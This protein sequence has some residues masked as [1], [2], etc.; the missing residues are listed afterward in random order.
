MR[1]MGAPSARSI[2][3]RRYR[4]EHSIGSGSYG[5][6]YAA[7]DTERGTEVALKQLHRVDAR[8]LYRFKRE[9]R[10]LARL[11][12]PNLV[13]LYE[14]F[15]EDDGWYLAMELVDG[16]PITEH[17][18]PKG[19]LPP[20]SPG[21]SLMQT[22]MVD[23]LSFSASGESDSDATRFDPRPTPLE[24][25]DEDEA[26]AH[27][28]G[29][30]EV[31][32]P[33]E[34]NPVELDWNRIAQVFG[35]V[36]DALATL[37]NAGMLHRDLKPHNVLVTQAGR[38]VVLDFG[39]VTELDTRG[40]GER[41]GMVIGTPNYMAPEQAS[42]RDV[43]PASDLYA[44]GVILYEVLTGRLPYEHPNLMTLLWRKVRGGAPK[45]TDI[46]PRVPPRLAELCDALLAVTPQS[47]PDAA[48]V[49]R[50][51]GGRAPRMKT[52]KNQA[53]AVVGRESELHQLHGAFDETV[54]K[55]EPRL[56]LLE[57]E[58]GMGKSA[59]VESFLDIVGQERH[60]MIL[61]GCCYEQDFVPYKAMDGLVDELSGYLARMAAPQLRA[62]LPPHAGELARLF[63]VFASVLQSARF[64]GGELLGDPIAARR[65][66]FRALRELLFRL[67]RDRPIV[68]FIDD[69]QW[70]DPQSAEILVDQLRPPAAPP[71]LWVLALRSDERS[72]PFAKALRERLEHEHE[73]AVTRIDLAPLP[74]EASAD[75]A[76]RILATSNP[77]IARR[78]AKEAGGHP[79]FVAEL[80]R[81]AR[82]SGSWEL[83]G[84]HSAETPDSDDRRLLLS[85]VLTDRLRKLPA[86]SQRLLETVAVAGF[87]ISAAA[88]HR[89]AGLERPERTTVHRLV[90]ARLLRTQQTGDIE[91]IAPYHS[92]IRSTV[93]DQLSPSRRRE[94][95]RSVGHALA[96]EGAPARSLLPHFAEA[97]EAELA[98][99]YAERAGDDAAGALAFTEAVGL[100][101]QALE[102]LDR[103]DAPASPNDRRELRHKLAEALVRAGRCREGARLHEAIARELADP[104]ERSKLELSAAQAY[105]TSGAVRQGDA[106]LEPL[107]RRLGLPPASSRVRMNLQTA[108][109]LTRLVLG[110]QRIADTGPI[111]KTEA[112]RIRACFTLA[113]SL[114]LSD[115][116]RALHYYIQGYELALRAGDAHS[117]AVGTAVLGSFFANLGWKRAE[118]LLARATELAQQV[119]TPEAL[120]TA[121]YARGLRAFMEDDWHTALEELESAHRQ[122]VRVRDS[123]GVRHAALMQIP[124]QLRYLDRFQELADRTERII[125]DARE[126][127]NPYTEAAAMVDRAHALLALGRA[128][129]TRHTTASAQR[130]A[131]GVAMYVR[132]AS[133]T[134]DTQTEL[135]LGRPERALERIE[136]AWSG[137]RKDGLLLIRAGHE[138]YGALRAGALLAVSE[139]VPGLRGRR[140]RARAKR[141]VQRWLGKAQT[142]FGLGRRATLEAALAHQA[143]D[144]EGAIDLL[145]LSSRH[146]ERASLP[147]RAATSR[148]RAAELMEDRTQ[149]REIDE[150][151]QALDVADPAR[152]T[153]AMAPGLSL[154]NVQSLD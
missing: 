35:D 101:E 63:P 28:L 145:A 41:T 20:L 38:P 51:L 127:G 79:L 78:I 1:L 4:I 21:A 139:Q 108:A 81:H 148:R 140:M 153:R 12:H 57:G 112:L 36:G 109:R 62:L 34:P 123:V 90:A 132:Y 105:Y 82:D 46:N 143:G 122:L 33:P 30:I 104:I 27:T 45:V 151:L 141:M 17:L 125:A 61:P 77:T 14:L 13:A 47:R 89:A 2:V 24:A 75:L 84:D 116:V 48:H 23:E 129:E 83:D 80:A 106:L 60:A 6:V 26:L 95:H 56:V 69:V 22:M 16:V 88:A 134:I 29:E 9:F 53:T 40:A 70:G 149:L 135:Y 102:W 138:F 118:V 68:A 126:V 74:A 5:N 25:T 67:A 18:R 3:G 107:G 50:G 137:L 144:R 58:S 86:G 115:L 73:L 52:P 114:T 131:P 113:P 96:D 66:G 8:G 10:S 124:T 64:K 147:V 43:G 15:V 128:T 54:Q 111:A 100:Y 154:R 152:W 94:L 71:V 121:A 150:L 42:G 32:G 87:P 117:V 37:H 19:A 7:I 133:V 92:R 99:R 39:L 136:Q 120:G 97:G 91:R 119:D 110:G 55:A 44:L 93:L 72:S 65:R 11:S 85:Q 76:E 103:T 130:K 146:F 59:L 142:D 98:A 31:D 49:A